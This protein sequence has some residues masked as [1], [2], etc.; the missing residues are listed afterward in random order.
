MREFALCQLSQSWACAHE[1]RVEVELRVVE[2][3]LQL[4]FTT[5]IRYLDSL[6][7]PSL[8][9]SSKSRQPD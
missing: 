5:L 4:F 1:Y 6:N 2:L 9:Q 7:K 8:A 3:F